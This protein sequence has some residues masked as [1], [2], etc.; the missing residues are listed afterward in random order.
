MCLL[1]CSLLI[2]LLFCSTAMYSSSVYQGPTDDNVA[3][4]QDFNMSASPPPQFER[5]SV[6]MQ[7]LVGYFHH[8]EDANSSPNIQP[9][10]TANVT[11]TCS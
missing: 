3:L 5:T 1:L 8:P 9:N 6:P 10:L 2:S 11:A 7:S 4:L